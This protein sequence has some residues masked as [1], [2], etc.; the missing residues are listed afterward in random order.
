MNQEEIKNLVSKYNITEVSGQLRAIMPKKKNPE[1]V[2]KIKTWKPE[3]LKYLSSEKAKTEDRENRINSID[4]LS[5]IRNCRIDWEVY[6][7]ARKS[8]MERMMETGASE[9]RAEK[10]EVTV[11]ELMER[12]PKAAAYLQAEALAWKTNYEMSEIGKKALERII[13]ENNF[14]S[15]IADM[16]EE[17]ENLKSTHL[18]D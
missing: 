9:M 3:I 8:A 15:V 4:G 6:N 13:F 16:N 12:F 1:D 11:S 5:E 14:E 17:L 18:W 10:P 2:E 7:S